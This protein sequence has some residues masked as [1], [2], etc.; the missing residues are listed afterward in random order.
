MKRKITRVIERYG[1]W[2]VGFINEIPGVNAQGKSL[3]EVRC[4][5]SEALALIAATDRT[6]AARKRPT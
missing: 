3:A 4:N 1:K 2:H 6:L 5:Q